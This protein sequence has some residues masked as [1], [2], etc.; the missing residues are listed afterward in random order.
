MP[1]HPDKR[2]KSSPEQAVTIEMFNHQTVRVWT[3]IEALR[4]WVTR[5]GMDNA[6]EIRDE[7]GE[8][9]RVIQIDHPCGFTS[10]HL[11]LP[12]KASVPV[13]YHECG[14]AAL[15][16][17]DLLGVSLRPLDDETFLYMQGFLA[18][19]IRKYRKRKK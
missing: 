16:L 9:G 5:M 4:C 8:D 15:I 18:E 1:K 2:K 13:I 6:R 7:H 19:S 12:R 14:H 17:C 3:S 10:V 11:Y